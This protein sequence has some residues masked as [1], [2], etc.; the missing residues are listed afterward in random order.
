MTKPRT[1]FKK[2]TKTNNMPYRKNHYLA[3]SELHSISFSIFF[4]LNKSKNQSWGIYKKNAANQFLWPIVGLVSSVEKKKR[5]KN[6]KIDDYNQT[7]SILSSFCAD[8]HF[9]VV[10]VGFIYHYFGQFWK[11]YRNFEL[12]EQLIMMRSSVQPYYHADKILINE[13]VWWNESVEIIMQLYFDRGL[14]IA[15]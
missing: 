15:W 3:F 8:Y 10:V 13:S 14:Y 6:K 1:T 5:N 4:F 11:E 9:F 12:T 2:K 7:W